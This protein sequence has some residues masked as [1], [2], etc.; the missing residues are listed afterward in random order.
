MKERPLSR[1]FL[2]VRS[3]T[4]VIYGAGLFIGRSTG[5]SVLRYRMD[6]QYQLGEAGCE[7]YCQCDQAHHNQHDDQGNHF[8]IHLVISQGLFPYH[9]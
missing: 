1:S 9:K 6:A 7:G 2:V 5:S 4:Q 8:L 3:S